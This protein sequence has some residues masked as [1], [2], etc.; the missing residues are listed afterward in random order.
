MTKYK[1]E[2]PCLY[3]PRGLEKEYLSFIKIGKFMNEMISSNNTKMRGAFLPEH[4]AFKKEV[5][6]S[7]IHRNI[8]SY[9]SM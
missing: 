7:L 5:Y 2:S 9:I 1:S 3:L 6:I 8:V 4:S